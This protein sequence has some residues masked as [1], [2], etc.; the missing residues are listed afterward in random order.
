MRVN[1][2]HD[3]CVHSNYKMNNCLVIH[4]NL[5]L[6]EQASQLPYLQYIQSPCSGSAIIS[7]FRLS[8]N[9]PLQ[10]Q[11]KSASSDS[12]IISL[13]RLIYNQPLQTDL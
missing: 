2:T 11:L 4:V 6:Q 1:R 9:Q 5:I 8:H 12:A 13:F 10:A 7:L 3:N